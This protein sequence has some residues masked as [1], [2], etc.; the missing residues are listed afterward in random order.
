MFFRKKDASPFDHQNTHCKSE[1]ENRLVIKVI[2]R[3][4]WIEP[5]QSM[6]IMN[7]LYYD[8]MPFWLYKGKKKHFS[9]TGETR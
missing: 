4:N 3:E 1:N 5:I 6:I 7:W 8:L 9:L 2:I